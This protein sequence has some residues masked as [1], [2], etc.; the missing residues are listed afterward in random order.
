MSVPVSERPQPDPYHS[1]TGHVLKPGISSVFQ[2]LEKVQ[3]YTTTN[4]MKLNE[5][6]TKLMIFNASRTIDFMPSFLLGSEEIEVLEDMKILGVTLT[7]DLKWRKNTDNIVANAYRRVWMVRRLKS[8]GTDTEDLIDVYIKQIRSILEFATPVW[9]PS[10]TVID[11]IRIE[12]VQKSVLHVILG[13]DYTSYSVALQVTNL[14]PLQS[15]RTKLCSKFALKA[16]QHPKHS[17]WFKENQ[18]RTKTRQKQPKFRPVISRTWRFS[19]SPISYLT[20]LLNKK[21]S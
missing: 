17:N 15:R 19:N 20:G 18:F 5:K 10:L 4:E 13:A 8:L 2:Q 3:Q 16:I 14:E 1:R 11:S 6:K 7:S 12:R 9:H 21:F